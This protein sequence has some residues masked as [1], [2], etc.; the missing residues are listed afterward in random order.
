M[1]TGV[2]AIVLA[3]LH[4]GATAVRAQQQA[5]G[6]GTTCGI[7]G[8]PAPELCVR[9]GLD[10]VPASYLIFVDESGSMK[11]IWP[12]VRAALADFAEAL[13]DG[14]KLDVRLF[15]GDVRTLIPATPSSAAT[16]QAWRYRFADLAMPAGAHTDLGKAADAALGSLAASPADRLQFVFFLTDGRH[17]P[18]PGSPFLSENACRGLRAQAGGIVGGRPVRV[19][20]IQLSPAADPGFLTC[21]FGG[22][23]VTSAVGGA[24]LRAWFLGQIA[25]ARV[26]KLRLLIEREL[27]RP[28]ARVTASAPVET[29][30]RRMREATL[31]FAGNRRVVSTL[32]DS[33]AVVALPGGGTLSFHRRDEIPPAPE[34]T[35]LRVRISGPACAWWK[36][37]R[38]CGHSFRA[39]LPV[40]TALEPSNELALLG[41]PTNHSDSI[42]ADLTLAASGL[43]GSWFVYGG[44][45]ATLA[46]V[47]V[48]VL[49]RVK[50]KLH[51][52]LLGGRLII[53]HRSTANGAEALETETVDLAANRTRSFTVQNATGDDL[54]KFEA[55]SRR[56]RTI[57]FAMPLA[58]NVEFRN[59]PM[60]GEVQIQGPGTFETVDTEV[61]FV[62]R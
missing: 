61:R 37:P 20:I 4:V 51:R 10:T 15:A 24:A 34:Q 14:D 59:K 7:A 19:G 5:A 17:D 50:W 57:V 54:V 58:D 12:A 33:T 8:F 22:A 25:E 47:V 48:L 9:A 60:T 21:V 28:A 46:A 53:R 23:I 13:P 1:R 36:P 38:S 40:A 62:P 29:R 26:H 16:R 44:M 39:T 45:L 56:G 41:F 30:S 11:P 43:V 42:Q 35:G 55:R 6:K 3:L 2:V 52:P 49:V 31:M 18:G 32:V 27:E